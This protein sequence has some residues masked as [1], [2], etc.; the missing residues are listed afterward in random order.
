MVKEMTEIALLGFSLIKE[1]I[2]SIL[3]VSLALS[4]RYLWDGAVGM[5]NWLGYALSAVYYLALEVGF[6]VEVCEAFGYGFYVIDA[7]HVLVD[8]ASDVV[9]P[10]TPAAE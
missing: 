7:I 9:P 6:G 5:G 3:L 8:F 4:S 10:E 1:S 2:V